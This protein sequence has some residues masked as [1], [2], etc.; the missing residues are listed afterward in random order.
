MEGISRK[1]L[2]GLFTDKLE[3]NADEAWNLLWEVA[4][5]ERTYTKKCACGRMVEIPGPDGSQR[6]KALELLANQAYGRPKET[7]Q[8]DHTIAHK[9]L[10]TLTDEDLERLLNQ[11][12]GVD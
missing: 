8:V 2:R 7:V 6:T 4:H 11:A 10:E 5:A 12:G 9:P 3:E 1:Q